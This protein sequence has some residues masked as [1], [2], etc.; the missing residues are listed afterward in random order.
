MLRKL[1]LLS[2]AAAAIG[3]SVAGAHAARGKPVWSSFPRGDLLVIFSGTGG[4]GYRFHVP[5][6]G[7]GAACRSPETTY[8][9]TDAYSW[10]DAFVVGPGGGTSDAPV[11]LAGSGQLSAT[12]QQ[13]RCASDAAVSGACSQALRPPF[14]AVGTDVAAPGVTVVMSGRLVTVGALSELVRG[15]Q[16]CSGGLALTPNVVTG[17]GGLQASVSFP[18]A[19]LTRDGDYRAPFTMAGSGLYAGVSLSGGCNA[20]G[21]DTATCAQDLPA[22]G[23]P[24]S[25]CSFGESYSGTIEVRVIR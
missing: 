2:A 23:G 25:S 22:T 16:T 4:G 14:G 13:G 19:A 8:G 6:Q 21:C 15:P 5:S 7:T 12:S 20:S 11:T 24:P 10:R 9:E 17:Y 3:A 1:L 18:R